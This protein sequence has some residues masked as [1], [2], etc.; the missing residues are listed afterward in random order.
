LSSID[1]RR[2]SSTRTRHASALAGRRSGA[3]LALALAIS[4]ALLAPLAPPPAPH[5]TPFG[6][7]DV[8]AGPAASPALEESAFRA[9]NSAIAV[10]SAGPAV[11]LDPAVTVAGQGG[12]L[13]T[14]R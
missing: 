3:P 10:G 4:L 13:L 2:D 5:V 11:T 1:R 14:Q 9:S 8:A 12:G 6:P 7:T